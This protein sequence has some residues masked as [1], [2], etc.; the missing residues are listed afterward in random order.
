[1]LKESNDQLKI[2]KNFMNF[3]SPHK[4]V[5]HP[6]SLKPYIKKEI[7]NQFGFN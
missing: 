4:I 3:K 2:V 6:D 1:M 5:Y 7:L